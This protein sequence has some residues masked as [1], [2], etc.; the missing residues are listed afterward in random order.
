MV[1]F[2]CILVMFFSNKYLKTDLNEAKLARFFRPST[3][4][5]RDMIEGRH[6]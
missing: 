5:E 3:G 4:F 6:L 1:S 2:V